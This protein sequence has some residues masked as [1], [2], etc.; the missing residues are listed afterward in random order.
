MGSWGAIVTLV[1]A[2]DE[3]IVGIRDGSFDDVL[4]PRSEYLF[5]ELS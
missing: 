4:R 1:F 5:F 2:Q 3:V